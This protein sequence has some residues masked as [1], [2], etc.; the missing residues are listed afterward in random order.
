M[1]AAGDKRPAIGVST[2]VI[3][4]HQALLV[5]R[6]KKAGF[7]LWSLPGGHV[8]WGEPLREAAARE[9][10]EETGI[11]CD[12]VRLLD[13]IDIMHRDPDGRIATH[14]V[15]S[16]F[17]GRWQSRVAAAA[18]DASDVKWVG[19]ADLASLPMTPGTADLVI[20]VLERETRGELQPLKSAPPR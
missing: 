10:Q 11:A 2:L 12:I 13:T 16:V 9:V 1:T 5:K 6:A 14:Y 19:P 20:R 7:G 18:S 3:R 8:E 15:V 17:L 4:D